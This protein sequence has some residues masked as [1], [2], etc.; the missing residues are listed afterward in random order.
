MA[1]NGNRDGDDDASDDPRCRSKRLA[2]QID[3]RTTTM[4]GDDSKDGPRQS[5]RLATRKDEND[6][7]ARAIESPWIKSPFA[8]KNKPAWPY[9]IV[10]IHEKT[11]EDEIVEELGM[12][13]T[14]DE[15][16]LNDIRKLVTLRYQLRRS[17]DKDGTRAYA[18]NNLLCRI[19]RKLICGTSLTA[20]YVTWHICHTRKSSPRN[21]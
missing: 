3:D 10:R 6:N 19:H 14:K 17:D 13:C 4:N 9:K 7:V 11:R 5:K 18:Q 12:L 2:K 1:D 21:W 15:N 20:F 8:N 16:F